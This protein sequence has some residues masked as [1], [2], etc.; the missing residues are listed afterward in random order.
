MHGDKYLSAQGLW[1]GHKAYT[2]GPK[3]PKYRTSRAKGKVWWHEG[4]WWLIWKIFQIYETTKFGTVAK[5]PPKPCKVPEIIE[6]L[7]VWA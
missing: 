6:K 1:C 4:Y 5:T 7:K 2:H 3:E